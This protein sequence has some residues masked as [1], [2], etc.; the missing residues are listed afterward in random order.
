MAR[1]KLVE[2]QTGAE[3]KPGMNIISFR[4]E[5]YKLVSFKVYQPP[6]TGR[7]IAKHVDTGTERELYPSVFGLKIVE[8]NDD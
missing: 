3:V 4:N 2:E 6:S 1:H 5:V 7:V 8:V